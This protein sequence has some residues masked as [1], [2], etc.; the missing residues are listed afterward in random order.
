[1]GLRYRSLSFVHMMIPHRIPCFPE[2]KWRFSMTCFWRLE[3]GVPDG[4][5]SASRHFLPI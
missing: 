2:H 4:N 5:P 3:V 1:M